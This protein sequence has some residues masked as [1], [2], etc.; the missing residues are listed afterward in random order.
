ML[1]YAIEGEGRSF[2]ALH[3]CLEYIGNLVQTGQELSVGLQSL[4][5]VQGQTVKKGDRILLALFPQFRIDAHEKIHRFLIPAPPEVLG[6]DVKVA[7][8]FRHNAC[9]DNPAPGGLVDLY[10]VV[11][12]DLV[13]LY[14]GKA[15]I[16]CTIRSRARE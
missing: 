10:A 2:L 1:K 13:S 15:P 16:A 6:D 3:V 8:P 11:V 5:V 7:E 12:L 4:V 14:S 9:H